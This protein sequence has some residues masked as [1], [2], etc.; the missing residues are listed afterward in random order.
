[1][2]ETSPHQTG[3]RRR[4]RLVPVLL[5][6]GWGTLLAALT[7]GL[8]S[9]A[10]PK[11]V[12]AA[13]PPGLSFYVGKSIHVGAYALLACLV[14]WLPVR[15]SVRVA[16]C[17]GLVGHGALTEY[18]QTLVEGRTGQLSDVGLD[19]IGVLLGLA[20]GLFVRRLRDR[21]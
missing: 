5:W 20:V 4:I 14:C 1:M 9:P 2:P 16:L 11:V 21:A 10:A 13:L 12:S 19:T 18:L 8:L 15:R 3:P 6:L 17:V 7:V